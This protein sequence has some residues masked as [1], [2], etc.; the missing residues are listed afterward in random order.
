MLI[1]YYLLMSITDRGLKS[2]RWRIQPR[3]PNA[4]ILAS[5]VTGF[6]WFFSGQQVRDFNAKQQQLINRI[7]QDTEA[8]NCTPP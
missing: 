2:F 1:N 3:N 5:V 4:L 7:E 8:D 6:A